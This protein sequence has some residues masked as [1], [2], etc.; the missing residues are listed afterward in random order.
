MKARHLCVAFSAILMLG[1]GGNIDTSDAPE[2]ADATTQPAPTTTAPTTTTTAPTTTTTT[3]AEPI[4]FTGTGKQLLPVALRSGV[5]IARI[6]SEEPY[7]V[8]LTDQSNVQV[9]MFNMNTGGVSESFVESR[10]AGATFMEV[11]PVGWRDAGTKAWTVTFRGF[12]DEDAAVIGRNGANPDV[13]VID[14]PSPTLTFT[15]DPACSYN[16]TVYDAKG[17]QYEWAF[18][19]PEEIASAGNIVKA[20]KPTGKAFVSISSFY[21]QPCG[22][23]WTE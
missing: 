13:L 1:C 22:W 8:V 5:K 11:S 3:T 10:A 18:A 6:E 4:V 15:V 9:G 17:S 7:N 19:A 21:P 12:T 16:V 23:T 2:V 14:T 20:R